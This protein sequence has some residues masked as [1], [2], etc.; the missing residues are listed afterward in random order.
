MEPSSLQVFFFLLFFFFLVFRKIL[1]GGQKLHKHL[2]RADTK[3]L[4][5]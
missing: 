2:D 4:E 3:Y 5:Y 1:A